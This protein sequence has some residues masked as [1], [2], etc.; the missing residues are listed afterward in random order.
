M[1][2]YNLGRITGLSAYEI[3]VKNGFKGT[4]QEWLEEMKATDE[5]ITTAVNNYISEN[6]LII[7]PDDGSVTIPK[8]HEELKNIL[9]T[10]KNLVNPAEFIEGYAINN[11]SYS[12]GEELVATAGHTVTGKI[13]VTGGKTYYFSLA[14]GSS[15]A[16]RISMH[17]KDG[18]KKYSQIS[19]GTNGTA[20]T[21]EENAEYFIASAITEMIKIMQIEKDQ[22][23]DYEEFKYV[24]NHGYKFDD[25][26]LFQYRGKVTDYGT[27]FVNCTQIGI[28]DFPYT[29]IKNSKIT[30]APSDIKESSGALFVYKLEGNNTVYQFIVNNQNQLYFRQ[31]TYAFAPLLGGAEEEEPKGT[32]YAVGDSI[33]QGW[34]SEFKAG[35][36]YNQAVNAAYGWATKL[37]AIKGYTLKNLAIGGTGFVDPND[38][39]TGRTIIDANSFANADFVTIAYGVNDWKGNQPIGT[40]E[41]DLT[42]GGTVISNMR[43]MIEKILNDNPL[44]K[45]YVITPL[46]CSMYGTKETNWGLGYSFETSGTL[47]DMFNAIVSV[48]EY[49]GIEYID[50]THQSVINRHNIETLMPDKVH[51][52]PEAHTVIAHE[53]SEKI[54]WL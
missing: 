32:W 6:G 25:N 10:S 50:M 38:D 49:Y 54:S 48:C 30:D 43:Y 42:T 37:A 18:T 39:D 11:L 36:G 27:A 14:S 35:G 53:I 24:V 28:Y 2:R 1:E 33:T 21:M 19:V 34:Y 4:E 15:T 31:G 22:K 29:D 51:P 52:T 23:T 45:I 8:L 9:L 44:C 26:H 40:M 20:L 46:N 41:D 7:Q 17:Y 5:Q 3:A 47:E 13:Y 16:V 12:T